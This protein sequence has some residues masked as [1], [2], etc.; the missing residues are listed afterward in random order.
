MA[1]GVIFLSSRAR[2]HSGEHPDRLA[3]GMFLA[4]FAA[5]YGA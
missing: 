4:L 2:Q 3:L 1:V 5:C